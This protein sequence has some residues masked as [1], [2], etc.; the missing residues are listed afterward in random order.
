MAETINKPTDVVTGK[1][2][3]TTVGQP[4]QATSASNGNVKTAIIVGGIA[5]A[6]IGVAL[7]L[8]RK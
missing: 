6:A 7:A 2:V 3:T 1:T 8:K 4:V 5:V